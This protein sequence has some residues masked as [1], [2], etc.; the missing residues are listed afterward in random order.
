M[1][2]DPQTLKW[3]I[4]KRN[5]EVNLSYIKQ[6]DMD[7]AN[8]PVEDRMNGNST[9][10]NISCISTLSKFFTWI[11]DGEFCTRTNG[12]YRYD[13]RQTDE[14]LQDA[15]SLATTFQYETRD[16]LHDMMP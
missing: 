6:V 12:V 10:Y 16:P 13:L 4:S 1:N 15:E 5:P 11:P 3:D 14:L 8:E 2:S 9:K 7:L